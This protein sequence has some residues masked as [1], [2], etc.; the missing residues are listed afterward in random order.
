MKQNAERTGTDRRVSKR[1][2][3]AKKYNKEED[4]LE[5]LEQEIRDLKSI[6]RSLLK[7]LKKIS[8]GIHKE[9]Y[10]EVLEE[11]QSGKKEELDSKRRC[12]E[13]SRTGLRETIIAGRR[14]ESCSV[15][16]YRSKRIKG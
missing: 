3:K 5:Q 14:F 15:C 12:P 4:K 9:E 10:E 8:R 2:R 6:N 13:C 11:I 7:Q 16:D 1:K